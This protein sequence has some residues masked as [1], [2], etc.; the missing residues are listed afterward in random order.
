MNSIEILYRE[1]YLIYWFFPITDCLVSSEMD[2]VKIYSDVYS[3]FF[4]L[5]H[6]VWDNIKDVC[7]FFSK[8]ENMTEAFILLNWR[9]ATFGCIQL[10]TF[11]VN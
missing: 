7:L 9:Y 11:K 3:L 2:K 4:Y 5:R 1:I 8:V 6:H 10:Q